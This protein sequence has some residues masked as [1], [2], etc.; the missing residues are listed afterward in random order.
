[1]PSLSDLPTELVQD[2]LQFVAV[3]DC[4]SMA[5]VNRRLSFEA[6][7]RLYRDI[8]LEWRWLQEYPP[9]S[10]LL[11]TLL[12][13]PDLRPL[14]K[15]LH[16]GGVGYM[17]TCSVFSPTVPLTLD[18]DKAV[19]LIR[20]TRF[21]HTEAWETAFRESSLD[22]VLA[23][24]V[25]LLPKLFR[26]SIIESFARDTRILSQTVL[27]AVRST[28][29]GERVKGE[30]K[31]EGEGDF[32][33]YLS[34]LQDVTIC[35]RR[36]SDAVLG[37]IPPFKNSP[38]ILGWFYLPSVQRLRLSI[39]NPLGFTWPSPLPPQPQHLRTLCLDQIREYR[40]LPILSACTG[41]KELKW[42]LR[43]VTGFD[44]DVLSAPAIVDLRRLTD[45]LAPLRDSLEVLALG[46]EIYEG[47]DENVQARPVTYRGFLDLAIL[48]KARTLSVPWIFY[49]GKRP[50]EKKTIGHPS[51]V[52]PKLTRLIIDNGMEN[53]LRNDWRD[54]DMREA[55]RRLLEEYRLQYT[56]HLRELGLHASYLEEV[57]RKELR[58]LAEKLG[59]V[60]SSTNECEVRWRTMPPVPH[61]WTWDPPP[62]TSN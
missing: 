28:V 46:A 58:L 48:T 34:N 10:K 52:P 39:D 11:R 57:S 59:L 20:S 56:P 37:K 25:I 31:G 18:K 27:H 4:V 26:L 61:C 44:S 17:N 3:E 55:A 47:L 30:A 53:D 51:T 22:A 32:W 54:P 50:R 1:M 60:F 13:N 40:A 14:V 35:Q 9:L 43:H 29:R 2:I 41:L 49:M 12:D 15:S 24:L 62:R 33:T 21:P 5:T 6:K 23:L 38:D 16:L 7:V 42:T 8:T 36:V 19:S 45:A